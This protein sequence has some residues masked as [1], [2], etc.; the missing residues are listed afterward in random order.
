MAI[1]TEVRLGARILI[2]DDEAA[3][4]RVLSRSLQRAGYT[5]LATT[6]DSRAVVGLVAGFA[7]DL[8]LLDLGMPDLDGFAVLELLAEA[9]GDDVGPPVLVV[10]GRQEPDVR[11]RCLSLGASDFLSRPYDEIEIGL[12]VDHL[13]TGRLL[14][15]SVRHANDQLERRVS[16]RTAALED[17]HHEI[18]ER[19]AKAAEFRDD[20]TGEHTQRVGRMAGELALQLGL[21][22][23]AVDLVRRAAP[24][25]DVGKI[26]IPDGVL[27][28]PD[29]LTPEEFEIIKTHAE[30]GA[31]LLGGSEIP[32]LVTARAVAHYHHE[33]W[34]GT[35]YPRKLAGE[36]IPL[37][38][39]ITA[40]ADVFDA[41]T[42]DRPYKRAWTVAAAREEIARLSG[43]KFD[44][45]IARAFLDGDF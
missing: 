11:R 28:K 17:A 39:R 43:T 10:T 30:I 14:L 1:S 33:N 32:L 35:G 40:L 24:L 26:A 23:R 42:H 44:P 15:K 2:V 9:A 27:L 7:P 13:I 16:E 29:K 8:I 31:R 4:I 36:N 38:A 37:A 20:D 25:H 45:T 6:M 19:L 34:D 22:P 21:D 12:R 3:N 5:N 41:L 18:L